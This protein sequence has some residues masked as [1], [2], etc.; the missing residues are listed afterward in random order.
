MKLWGGL[1]GFTQITCA[2]NCATPGYSVFLHDTTR[3]R[4]KQV[5]RVCGRRCGQARFCGSFSSGEFPPQATVPRTSGISLSGQWMGRLSSQSKRATNCATPGYS[6]FLHD[7]MRR[8]KKQVFRVCGRCCGHARFFGSFSTGEF[9]PQSTV[10]RTSGV[11]LLGEW[12]GHLSTQITCATNCATPGYSIFLHDTMQRRK[13]QVFRVCGRRCGHAQFCGSFSTDRF[14]PQATV[15]R[16]S[17]VPL[18]GE[19]MSRLSSQITRAANYATFGHRYFSR[20]GAFFP[21]YVR[22][23]TLRSAALALWH[24]LLL[25]RGQHDGFI[26][27]LSILPVSPPKSSLFASGRYVGKAVRRLWGLR[28][29]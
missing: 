19:W 1:G 2:T 8:R 11:P 5:S 12:I 14:P 23:Y 28:T 26:L 9:P 24:H 16:T 4:K 29:A 20:P 6:V 17:G 15:P 22:Q 3:G 27:Y 21:T 10:P 25:D 7:T 13:K 18:L